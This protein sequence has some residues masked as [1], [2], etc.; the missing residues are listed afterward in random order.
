METIQVTPQEKYVVD[1]MRDLIPF[2][3]IEVHKDPSGKPRRFR[4][5]RSQDI[6]LTETTIAGI[7]IKK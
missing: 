3:V 1:A 7:I 2:E 4:I 6:V 5:K